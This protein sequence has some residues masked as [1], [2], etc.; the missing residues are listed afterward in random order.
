MHNKPVIKLFVA[1]SFCFVPYLCSMDT[2]DTPCTETYKQITV[3]NDSKQIVRVFTER[4][5]RVIEIN[6]ETASSQSSDS[7][8]GDLYAYIATYC[9]PKPKSSGST[10]GTIEEPH[11]ILKPQ[12]SHAFKISV[13]KVMPTLNLFQYQ[14]QGSLN[15]Y[16]P[17]DTSC[18]I[19]SRL[20]SYTLEKQPITTY[21]ITESTDSA[22]IISTL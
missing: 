1:L 5:F 21:R 11:C 17:D 18:S 6:R 7:F 4:V 19:Q 22:L 2:I 15:L 20:A 8:L 14:V 3:R 16:K 9:Y 13:S 10:D 12:E